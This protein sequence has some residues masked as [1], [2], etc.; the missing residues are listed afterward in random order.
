MYINV[1]TLF[2]YLINYTTV[3]V[4]VCEFVIHIFAILCYYLGMDPNKLVATGLTTPQAE[5]YALLLQTGGATPPQAAQK[6]KITRTNA[7]KVLDKLVEMHLATKDESSKKAIYRPDN[8]LALANLAAQ[9]RN[10][11]TARED[12]VKNILKDLLTAYHTHAEQ[13]AVQAVT[14]REAVVEAYRQQIRQLQPIIFIRSNLDIPILGF[15]TMHTIRTEPGRH[16]VERYG[17]TPD[18]GTD[19]GRKTSLNR[20][21]IRQEDYTAPVEW[22]VCGDIL[23]IVLFGAEPHAVT[24]TSPV[25]AEAFRQLWHLLN[26]CVR[27]MPYYKDLPRH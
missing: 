20:T 26:T 22:S 18:G 27:A 17:I 19:G 8:P 25:I 12:A 3:I 15:D 9:Q 4:Y 5:A 7:Y 21:W 16:G 24:I 13:P 11:A 10:I 6:L 23:L 14:G 2:T 1:N